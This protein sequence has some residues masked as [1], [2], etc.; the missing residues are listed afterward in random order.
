MHPTEPCNAHHYPSVIMVAYCTLMYTVLLHMA[1]LVV[2]HNYQQKFH[3]KAYSNYFDSITGKH[4]LQLQK[5]DEMCYTRSFLCNANR[6][7]IFYQQI[8]AWS[9][10]LAE[11]L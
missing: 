8:T 4:V 1:G 2:L 10:D 9:L 7:K 3:L 11:R 6:C 5:G